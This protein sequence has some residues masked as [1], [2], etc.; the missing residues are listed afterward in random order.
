MAYTQKGRARPLSPVHRFDGRRPL[1]VLAHF[2]GYPPEHNAG[3]EWMAHT[4]MR[5]LVE[6]GSDAA[7]LADMDAIEVDGV[8]VDRATAANVRA[9]YAWAD[10]VVTH[11]DRTRQ[12]LRFSQ[13]ECIP[14]VHLVHNDRQL[15]HNRIDNAEL[16]VWNSRWIADAHPD[17]PGPS[18]VVRP[19]VIGSD[20]TRPLDR[21]GKITLVNLFE[22]KGAD[23]FYRLAADMPARQ[24]L[25]VR[26]AYGIQVA[27]PR[28]L[29]NVEVI[30]STP[31][32][33]D[34]VYARTRVLLMPSR[35]ESWGRVAVEALASGIP[36]IAAP[37]PGLRESLHYAGRFADVADLDEWGAAICELDDPDR[38]AAA[39]TAALNRS[40]ELTDM[41][42]A[43]LDRWR[44]ALYC[45][46]A[47]I[48]LD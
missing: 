23:V 30:N 39:S 35:Y 47:G 48:P 16:V 7:V 15:A 3:A 24:F 36:V 8:R 44:T 46:A 14:L 12:A 43:D 29:R 18:I 28:R 27:P 17:W 6:H 2:H 37:T 11:L 41:S 38:Y 31:R 26:G 34:D 25:G 33:A 5:D 22:Q 1:R 13:A 9:G 42:R 20:Y 19:P 32:I 4:M 45:V 21:A 40:A 10:V